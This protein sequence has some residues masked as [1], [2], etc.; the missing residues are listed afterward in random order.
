MVVISILGSVVFFCCVI[1]IL[2]KWYFGAP[3]L[4]RTGHCP[5]PKK[6]PKRGSVSPLWRR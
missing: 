2:H 6:V 1:S 3:G 5:L 4:R